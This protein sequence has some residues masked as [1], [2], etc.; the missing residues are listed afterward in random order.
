MQIIIAEI[1]GS[2]VNEGNVV[3]NQGSLIVHSILSVRA[4]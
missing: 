2:G 4:C 1:W 3:G